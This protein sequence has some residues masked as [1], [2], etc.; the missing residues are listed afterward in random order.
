MPSCSSVA[1]AVAASSFSPPPI[2]MSEDA[3]SVGNDGQ[4]VLETLH[5]PLSILF[6]S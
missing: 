2:T 5:P 1:A 4:V 6:R 3:E